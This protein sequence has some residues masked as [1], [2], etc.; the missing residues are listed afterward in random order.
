MEHISSSGELEAILWGVEPDEDDSIPY[1]DPD[2]RIVYDV[3]NFSIAISEALAEAT[4]EHGFNDCFDRAKAALALCDPAIG[5]RYVEGTLFADQGMEP[6]GFGRH[7]WLMLGDQVI[8]PSAA[9][10]FMAKGFVTGLQWMVGDQPGSKISPLVDSPQ[11]TA[12]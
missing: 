8:D 11:I 9:A 5:I 4:A 2:E 6:D 1:G 10:V 7:A 3:S 12:P